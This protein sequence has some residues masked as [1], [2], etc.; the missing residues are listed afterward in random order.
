VKI[1]VLTVAVMIVAF[2][3]AG[4]AMAQQNSPTPTPTP[5]PTPA[6]SEIGFRQQ[7]FKPSPS[8]P[9]SKPISTK[10]EKSVPSGQR[11]QSVKQPHPTTD[12]AKLIDEYIK[13]T[14]EYKAS[15]QKL[16][17]LYEASEHKAEQRLAQ[18]KDLYKDGLLSQP[19]VDASE[20][21]LAA[22][23]ERVSGVEQQ[24][25]TADTQ[26]A[27]SLI[28]LRKEV[29]T[30]KLA[31]EYRR[32]SARQPSCRNWTLTASRQ[33]RGSTVTMAFKLVCKD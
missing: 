31:R 27:R 28:E 2:A 4:V 3:R 33:E 11:K 22:E 17:A 12:I 24:I 20:R 9:L 16:L 23:K 19:Q 7:G 1:K 30:A 25:A 10:D 8:D 21:A 18:S 5:T 13:T 29:T 26:I 6:Q 32:A 14:K 15:L